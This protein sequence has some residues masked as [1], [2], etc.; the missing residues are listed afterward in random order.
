MKRIGKVLCLL[1]AVLLLS[2]MAAS[3]QRDGTGPLLDVSN[4]DETPETPRA[5]APEEEDSVSSSEEEDA[6]APS[7]EQS[8]EPSVPESEET[9]SVGESLGGGDAFPRNP[10]AETAGTPNRGAAVS[11]QLDT[12]GF[13]KNNVRLLDLK[14]KSLSVLTTEEQSPF[15][16][17]NEQGDAV[18]ELQW[19]EALEKAYGLRIRYTLA[20]SDKLMDQA[21]VLMNAGKGPDVLRTDASSFPKAF[22]LA[23][24]LT[25]YIQPEQE[26]PGVDRRLLEETRWGGEYYCIAPVGAVNVLWYDQS[27]VKQLGLKDPHTLWWEDNWTW[28]SFETFLRSIPATLNDTPLNAYGQQVSDLPAWSLIHGCSSVEINTEAKGARLIH[29]MEEPKL[30]ESWKS[31]STLLQSVRFGGGFSELYGGTTVM[32][33]G[34][35]RNEGA[36]A[37]K[38]ER[39]QWVPFP[40][41]TVD[42]NIAVS[43]GYTM[44]L[45]KKMKTQSNA[46]YAVKFMELWATRFA[47]TI[48]DSFETEQQRARYLDFAGG[49][50]RFSLLMNEWDMLNETD[51]LQKQKWLATFYDSRYNIAVETKA[52]T[53]LVEQAIKDCLAYGA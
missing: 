49:G 27:V 11:V 12:T 34:V 48:L 40:K 45:P 13:V 38:G 9:P 18:G 20:R 1:L 3:C 44:M 53:P 41:G 16:Y 25:P 19:W 5:D 52:M 50:S 39:L 6:R 8:V 23:Q 32:V 36:E 47:E 46:P 10:L 42:S 51:V 17:I 15:R 24:S 28:S 43:S 22:N 35:L 37:L 31:V 4:E 26:S 21:L 29:N 14:R 30:L 2:G 7:A 33:A